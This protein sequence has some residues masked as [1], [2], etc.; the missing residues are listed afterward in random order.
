MMHDL[1][2][3]A[4][5]RGEGHGI[6][7]YFRMYCSVVWHGAVAIQGRGGDCLHIPRRYVAALAATVGSMQQSPAYADQWHAVAQLMAPANPHCVVSD[8]T[9]SGR[10]PR[11]Q[12]SS[13]G[14]MTREAGA[15]GEEG[16]IRSGGQGKS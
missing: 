13:A 4:R 3:R 14:T 9:G 6:D 12:Y 15:S 2:G 7:V 11:P 16:P 1:V 8:S 10:T 5:P